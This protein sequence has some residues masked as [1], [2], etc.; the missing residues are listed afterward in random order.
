MFSSLGSSGGEISDARK[1]ELIYKLYTGLQR[2][3]ETYRNKSRQGAKIE[4][5]DIIASFQGILTAEDMEYALQEFKTMAINYYANRLQQGQ[6]S[7]QSLFQQEQP[8]HRP[9]FD[10]QLHTRMI[11]AMMKSIKYKK[12][13]TPDQLYK[14]LNIK[15]QA[16]K[17]LIENAYEETLIQVQHL[18]DL[19]EQERQDRKP[20][21]TKVWDRYFAQVNVNFWS[22]IGMALT[23]LL[24][25]FVVFYIMRKLYEFTRDIV[26]DISRT[27]S[28]AFHRV[29]DFFDIGNDMYSLNLFSF[30]KKKP[31]VVVRPTNSPK[32]TETFNVEA[33]QTAIGSISKAFTSLGK[34][35]SESFRSSPPHPQPSPKSPKQKSRKNKSPRSSRFIAT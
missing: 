24:G 29:A 6:L 15:D 21:T 7:P 12:V 32:K 18:N 34:A 17:Q 27:V 9:V 8:V 16:T 2:F 35:A 23:G 4:P 13:P 14:E 3:V 22:M 10:P 30:E 11:T 31:R 1:R 25:G 28:N 20:V 5:E 19:L 33:L 26:V